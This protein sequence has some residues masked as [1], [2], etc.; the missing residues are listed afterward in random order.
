MTVFATI[1]E[2][3]KASRSNI[4]HESL[5]IDETLD[6]GSTVSDAFQYGLPAAIVS[7][8]VGIANTG[9]AFGN[10]LGGDFQSV[11]VE[12]TLEDFG[13]EN[14]S[15][16]YKDH[17]ST[18]DAVGFGISAIV[19]GVAGF[20]AAGLAQKALNASTSSSR[21][22]TGLKTVL[23]P[24]DKG[25]KYLDAVAKSETSFSRFTLGRKAAAQG[26]H[27]NLV[28][29]AFAETAILLTAA[30]NPSIS[31]VDQ[32]YGEAILDNIGGLTF[33]IVL[34]TGIGG[35]ISGT[36]QYSTLKNVYGSAAEASNA[37]ASGAKLT[38]QGFPI[39]SN[40]GDNVAL[41]W[42][43]LGA[44][45]SNLEE[46][47]STVDAAALKKLNESIQLQ[48][49][50]IQ[51]TI[52][53]MTGE[54]S[55][56]G[57]LVNDAELTG[58]ITRA[59][60][61]ASPEQ[62][63]EIFSNLTK[64]SR[65][66]DVD[67][68]MNPT[69]SPLAVAP[70]DEFAQVANDILGTPT[71]L[72][73]ALGITIG[74]DGGRANA[75]V[76]RESIMQ[77][78]DLDKALGVLRHEMGH[79]N[80]NRLA[81][82]WD[83][84][85]ATSIVT[86]AT[87]LSKIARPSA[88]AGAESLLNNSTKALTKA[89]AAGASDEIIADLSA[90][91]S[92][93]QRELDFLS[94]PKD[95][96]ADSWAMFNRS[97][98]D[99]IKFSKEF[100]SVF[101]VLSNNSAIKMMLGKTE[102]VMDLK[103]LDMYMIPDRQPTIADLG[104]VSFQSN[105][106][107]VVYANGV[108]D[109]PFGRN[110]NLKAK[111]Y[112][113][114]ETTDSEQASA[115]FFA[116]NASIRNIPNTEAIPWTDFASLNTILK[117]ADSGE[118][119]QPYTI[120]LP[121]G[122]EQVFNFG[123]NA[124]ATAEEN[125]SR[126]R[127]QYRA[128][129]MEAIQRIRNTSIDGKPSGLTESEIARI[130]DSHERF[131]HHGGHVQDDSIP[132][133]S[134]EYNPNQASMVKMHYNVK[135]ELANKNI[136]EGINELNQ[137]N[138]A[139]LESAHNAVVS[140]GSRFSSGIAE[141]MPMP[142]FAS[143][144]NQAQEV[145]EAT[146]LR[147]FLHSTG[148]E[149][150]RVESFVQGVANFNENFKKKFYSAIDDQV[151]SS[152]LILKNDSI[153]LQEAA[154]LDSALRR[155]FYKFSP[156][157]STQTAD[158]DIIN[159]ISG[160]ADDAEALKRVDQIVPLVSESIKTASEKG[161]VLWTRKLEN[162]L[163]QAMKTKKFGPT[164]LDRI[165]QSLD[166]GI[167]TIQNSKLEMFWRNK[168]AMNSTIVEGKQTIAGI[169]GL[170]SNLDPDVLYP[171]AFDVN[172]FKHRKFI[173]PRKNGMFTDD[174]AGI[175]ASTTP[176]GLI[177]KERQVRDSF[178]DDVIILTADDI[179][180]NK[181]LSGQ[182]L[183]GLDLTESEIDS[184]MKRKG[185]LW[186]VVPEPS[187]D[188]IDHYIRDMKGQAKGIVDNMTEAAY[189]DE[190]STLRFQ[191]DRIQLAN[192]SGSSAGKIKDPNQEAMNIMTNDSAGEGLWRT[193]QQDVD[194]TISKGMNTVKGMFTQ[195]KTQGDYQQMNR[196]MED[197]GLP[198]V[199]TNK[200]GKF[201]NENEG[202]N[203]TILS[204]VVPQA[205]G[206]AATMMLRLDL[207]QPLVTA[208]STPITALPELK[209]LLDSVPVL[210]AQQV[211]NSLKVNIPRDA[212]LIEGQIQH[213]M[214]SNTKL[215]YQ[216]A[217]DYWDKPELVKQYRDLG[218]TPSIVQ[219]MREQAERIALDPTVLKEAGGVSKYKGHIDSL[220]NTLAKPADFM[221]GFVKFQA[222]RMADL[223]L[224]AAGVTDQATKNLAI[225]TYVKRVHGNYTYAQRPT[226][227]QGF[228]GQAIGLFQTYQFNMI[229]QMMRHIGDKNV[230]AAT[231]MLGIQA[232]MFGAQS[233]PGFQALNQ[234]IGERS[235][236][237]RDFYTGAE[238]VL[239]SEVS[240]WLLYGVSSNFTK[241]VIDAAN[242]IGVTDIESSGLSLFSRGDLTPRTPILLP[243]SMAEIP[244]INL[245]TK[246]IN[247]I[248]D[249]SNAVAGGVPVSEVFANALAK[250]GVNRPLSGIGQLLGGAK[251]TTKGSLIAS[252]Q[253]VDWWSRMAKLAGTSD[254]DE[255]IAIQSYYRAKGYDSY[256]RE[257]LNALGVKTKS[258]VRSGQYDAKTHADTFERY[259]ELG[260]NAEYYQRWLHDQYMGAT[261]SIIEE[262]RTT[263]NSPSGRYLQNLMGTESETGIDPYFSI[264]PTNPLGTNN[265]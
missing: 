179:R 172:K 193:A 94:D 185:I 127:A 133:W 205:N 118:L 197:A 143:G 71:Q 40:G 91:V 212:A 64:L 226:M 30:K 178:G 12:T 9:I 62:A 121:D 219:E 141:G 198:L 8:A 216:A 101:K 53:S 57:E 3:D 258:M 27:Q 31:R 244:I 76:V 98:A 156:V 48:E 23:V 47:A 240:E 163:A 224:T 131:V 227:F 186:D 183:Q 75:I 56:K 81:N 211:R 104:K 66:S 154:T 235:V 73:D 137:R 129:K 210:K 21:L 54:L 264:Q 52:A 43:Q 243:T 50:N 25:K 199:Y 231:S 79:D 164:T 124:F 153:A 146:S 51:D 138:S 162:V 188:I 169:R 134:S 158:Q 160:F 84:N 85:S 114:L 142:T 7:G 113:V 263:H 36:M 95:L 74:P 192:T 24:A 232:G 262:M 241:P 257:H 217:K 5:E 252:Q 228:A 167:I 120:S 177:A 103:T 140:F 155:D 159:Y 149:Y 221:E 22:V 222:A 242:F 35:V 157:T 11:D 256:R 68:L 96:L 234:H 26:F 144:I 239:G 119:L 214:P 59:L 109:T 175:I 105:T 207:I 215:M 49:Q 255:G 107:K 161:T 41:M 1:S 195:A 102:A 250:N 150:G 60:R 37:M 246:F 39:G 233:V 265:Q 208:L 125:L 251:T 184:M 38:P 213:S 13:W 29:S 34:G 174:K 168:V 93:A 116:A 46:A 111:R 218:F 99:H 89:K 130:T 190:F 45:K 69:V 20:K 72:D 92:R 16:Y 165:S 117:Q 67:L 58:Q 261:T 87:A 4:Y 176:E 206:A 17:K 253:D 77:G 78:D 14:S 237:G 63:T 229:Q 170:S 106:G 2:E 42:N 189:A 86:D 80:A 128:L 115:F 33:G 196:F 132:F 220:V 18:I 236:E 230:R 123:K 245:S 61:D 248:L 151:A 203:E 32:S 181:K 260:G 209:H 223:T 10:A 44:M 152:A 136:G 204:S 110:T 247:N 201:L 108:V 145:T 19:P 112:N 126:F 100:P 173:H 82:A 202:I 187:P 225:L 180:R 191:S 182:Y 88:W 254:L 148:G 28:E 15:A 238:D 135:S 249:T 147:G 6:T 194:R 139:N 97:E 83:S 65:H 166:G 259:A 70:D 200:T 171:G 122:T 55:K 90:Q